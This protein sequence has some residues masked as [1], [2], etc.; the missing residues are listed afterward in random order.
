MS[1]VNPTSDEVLVYRSGTSYSTTADMSTVNN[2]DLIIVN[3]SGTD[4]KCTFADWQTSQLQE[5]AISSLSVAT[6]AG[7]ARFTSKT[8]QVSWGMDDNGNPSSAKAFKAYV[9]KPNNGEGN[10]PALDYLL[11]FSTISSTSTSG[12]TVTINLSGS[13]NISK[14]K[15]GD[16][17][18]PLNAVLRRDHYATDTFGGNNPATVWAGFFDGNGA[19]GGQPWWYPNPPIPFNSSLTLDGGE[20]G[21]DRKRAQGPGW[22]TGYFMSNGGNQTL[23]S[24]ANSLSGLSFD[25]YRSPTTGGSIGKL[26]ID[27]NVMRRN[28]WDPCGVVTAISG[29]TVTITNGDNNE[30]STLTKWA[31]VN[32]QVLCRDY[33]V[34]NAK[35]SATDIFNKG[36]FQAPRIASKLYCVFGANG[37]ITDFQEDDPGWVTLTDQA[38]PVN[39]V[40]P[41][42]ATFSACD[43]D[44]PTGSRLVVE[45]R[46]TNSEGT[47]YISS[48][49]LTP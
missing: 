27:G 48:N 26:Y 24:G 15:V 39:L 19:G 41:A 33:H 14:L 9:L 1:T 23:Y 22:D 29:N 35:R 2:S 6:T 10:Y 28:V 42:N 5:P 16:T 44:F 30:G 21:Y 11:K 47:A 37:S 13:T 45:M 4:Y 7:A 49:I 3:R 43:T 25:D 36:G 32:G 31:S 20:P 8:F 34:A 38:S 18:R 46:A 12:T 17:V 40:M